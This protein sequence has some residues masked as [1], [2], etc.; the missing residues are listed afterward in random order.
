MLID[1]KFY[2]NNGIRKMMDFLA[3]HSCVEKCFLEVLK[4]VT[5]NNYEDYVRIS[6]CLS[7]YSVNDFNSFANA[8]ILRSEF[9]T[10]F[11]IIYKDYLGFDMSDFEI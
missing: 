2:S 6:F 10:A 1:T 4:D 7:R 11:R 3:T 9:T 8:N 5:K